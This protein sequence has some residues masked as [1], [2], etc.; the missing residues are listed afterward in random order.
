MPTILFIDDHTC[1]SHTL[2]HK[3][4]AYGYEVQVAP[5]TKE[6]LTLFRL[7]RHS[8]LL[9]L[10]G[11]GMDFAKRSENSMSRSAPGSR[12]GE[13]AATTAASFH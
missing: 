6:A 7:C 5:D 4:Q 2:A 9:S 1:G 11:V 12:S 8:P 13:R 3:L 10:V